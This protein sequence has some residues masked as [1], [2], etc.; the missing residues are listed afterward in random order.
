MHHRRV[1]TKRWKGKR[2]EAFYFDAK[3][4]SKP[5]SLTRIPITL[6]RVYIP[7]QIQGL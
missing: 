1:C 2:N 6:S 5:V 3:H 7:M 4:S